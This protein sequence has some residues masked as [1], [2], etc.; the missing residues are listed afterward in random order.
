MALPGTKIRRVVLHLLIALVA[1]GQLWSVLELAGIRLP[2][3][4]S[5]LFAECVF[6]A[7]ALIVAFRRPAEA[8]ELAP[9]AFVGPAFG[10]AISAIQKSGGP[11]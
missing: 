10:E 8:K 9:W 2:A 6:I 3:P 7:L 5:V 11:P 4:Y 1:C